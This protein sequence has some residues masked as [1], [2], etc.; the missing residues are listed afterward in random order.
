MESGLQLQIEKLEAKL[1]RYRRD[2]E[3]LQD[4]NAKSEVLIKIHKMQNFRL[5]KS[6]RKFI[7]PNWEIKRRKWVQPETKKSRYKERNKWLRS[8]NDTLEQNR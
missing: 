2:N 8:R 4:L 6:Y 5:E 1:K 7:C 3:E